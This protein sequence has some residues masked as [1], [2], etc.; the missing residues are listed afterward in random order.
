MAGTLSIP[1]DPGAE[2]EAREQVYPEGE[3]DD[4]VFREA[5]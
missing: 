2:E 5:G 4:T 1:Q 3:P